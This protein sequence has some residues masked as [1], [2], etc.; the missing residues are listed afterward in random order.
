M[1]LPSPSSPLR[2]GR[3]HRV[4]LHL[5]F[6]GRRLAHNQPNVARNQVFAWNLHVSIVRSSAAATNLFLSPLLISHVRRSMGGLL[7]KSLAFW[8]ASDGED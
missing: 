5:M 2:P 3:P 6:G 8:T 7:A 1:A 4:L